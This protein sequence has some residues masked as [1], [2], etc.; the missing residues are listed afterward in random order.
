MGMSLYKFSRGDMHISR[1]ISGRGTGCGG[2]GG[3]VSSSL[4]CSTKPSSDV[5]CADVDDDCGGLG[6]FETCRKEC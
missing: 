4:P 2:T 5:T 3:D 1:E 6:G